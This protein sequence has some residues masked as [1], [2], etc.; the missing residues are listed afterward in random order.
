MTVFLHYI[1][2]VYKCTYILYISDFCED[3]GQMRGSDSRCEPPSGD[4][5]VKDAL[6]IVCCVLSLLVLIEWSV[7]AALWRCGV[8][9]DTDLTK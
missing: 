1:A 2:K 7:S 3:G 8:I 6:V 5:V 9:T 4:N